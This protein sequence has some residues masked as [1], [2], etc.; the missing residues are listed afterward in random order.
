MTELLGAIAIRVPSALRASDSYIPERARR[1]PIAAAARFAP[2][3]TPRDDE[4]KRAGFFRSRPVDIDGGV[5]DGRVLRAR[6]IDC[7]GEPSTVYPAV[8]PSAPEIKTG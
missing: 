5:D 1:Q 7:M 4:K 2:W 6:L 8:H 3:L